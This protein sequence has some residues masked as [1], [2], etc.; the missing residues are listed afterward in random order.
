MSL[1]VLAG[2]TVYKRC[3]FRFRFKDVYYDTDQMFYSYNPCG[4]FT[5]GDCSEAAVSTK[6][7][8]MMFCKGSR[9][10]LNGDHLGDN[11]IHNFHLGRYIVGYTVGDIVL[12]R[13]ASS[14]VKR[15]FQTYIRR[16]TSTPPQ[17][18]ILYMV[19]PILMH[20]CSFVSNWSV[21]SRIIGNVAQL[22]TS[23]CFLHY[24]AGYTVANF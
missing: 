1:S 14:A 9:V 16:Y 12:R 22:M 7:C 3:C 2:R 11:C 8:T 10:P 17:M 21:A 20:F 6:R 13:R 23:N 15:D 18:K 5:E 24:I 19:I 4:G